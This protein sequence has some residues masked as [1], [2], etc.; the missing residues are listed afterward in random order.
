MVPKLHRH[1][2]SPLK[3]SVKN[4]DKHMDGANYYVLLY[5]HVVLL[6]GISVPSLNS[7]GIESIFLGHK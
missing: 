5:A 3:N 4:M 1:W 6:S 2:F 7:Q